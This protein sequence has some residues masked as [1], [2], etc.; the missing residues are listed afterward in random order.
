MYLCSSVAQDVYPR[1][2]IPHVKDTL[3]RFNEKFA[4][5]EERAQKSDP[6]A[7]QDPTTGNAET[8]TE[9]PSSVDDAAVNF[10]LGPFFRL[11]LWPM[12]LIWL[13]TSVAIL[14][15]LLLALTEETNATVLVNRSLPR[16]IPFLGLSL[17]VIIRS[18][19]WIPIVG[20]IIALFRLPR[21][22]LAPVIMLAEEK[23]LLESV[24]E[25]YRRSKGH[26]GKI[27]GNIFVAG[28]V[29]GMVAWIVRI[30][31]FGTGTITMIAS[32]TFSD[33]GASIANF[34]VNIVEVMA[35][36]YSTI[37]TAKLALEF[38]A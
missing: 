26:S 33:T 23:G 12:L 22:V 21:F 9:K 17:W 1:T 15:F 37:F 14:L 34:V 13:I 24:S 3:Q 5:P 30:T 10:L 18:F 7:V 25:S 38:R 11:I 8:L 19:V 20:P 32:M 4:A 29:A 36:A 35:L 16:V 27:F 28:M 31:I 2:A 6:T